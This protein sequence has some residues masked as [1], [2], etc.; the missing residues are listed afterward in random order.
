[1]S[2]LSG[3]SGLSERCSHLL[4]NP[5]MV[6]NGSF[7]G[8]SILRIFAQLLRSEADGD[9]VVGVLIDDDAA[10]FHRASPGLAVDL[11]DH[12]VKLDGIVPID[13]SLGL[14]R[15]HAGEILSGAWDKGRF[16]GLLRWN[17]KTA[18]ELADVAPL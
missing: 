16:A 3:L 15:K 12:I 13:C 18:V 7:H 6:V 14:N 17:G 2:G 8:P 10:A 9:G 11:Q 5:D 1:M 4:L